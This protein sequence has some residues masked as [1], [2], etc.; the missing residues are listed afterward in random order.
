[1]SC[2]RMFAFCSSITTLLPLASVQC[3]SKMIERWMEDLT[4]TLL[5][6]TTLCATSSLSTALRK[7]D[8][9]SGLLKARLNGVSIR[10]DASLPLS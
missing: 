6:P 8:S 3:T 9:V 7:C 2:V 10:N 4:S 1:M 5:M